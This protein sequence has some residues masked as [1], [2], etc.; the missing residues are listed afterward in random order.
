MSSDSDRLE[1]S[2]TMH[3]T[4]TEEVNEISL[5]QIQVESEKSNGHPFGRAGP[6]YTIVVATPATWATEPLDCAPTILTALIPVRFKG[7]F[8][9]YVP[10]GKK[11]ASWLAFAALIAAWIA[12]VSSVLP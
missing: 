2:N 4:G 7:A 9:R 11:T 12:W 6:P 5:I 1:P 10:S 3:A 8:T